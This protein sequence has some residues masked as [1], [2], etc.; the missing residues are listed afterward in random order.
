MI[1]THA[2]VVDEAAEFVK[3]LTT[4]KALQ[5]EFLAVVKKPGTDLI[6]LS[7][8]VNKVV[9]SDLKNGLF[10]FSPSYAHSHTQLHVLQ[11]KLVSQSD[12]GESETSFP[13]LLD[14]L[15]SPSPQRLDQLKALSIATESFRGG[16]N[17]IY[18]TT[19]NVK[20]FYA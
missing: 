20:I 2:G 15:S 3:A 18:S 6:K 13:E 7:K 4:S 9:Q 12:D 5:K 16:Y 10:I 8:E 1:H 14:H 17:T 19:I 11:E